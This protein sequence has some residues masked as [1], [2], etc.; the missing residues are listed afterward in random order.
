MADG[1]IFDGLT[2]KTNEDGSTI[3][4]IHVDIYRGKVPKKSTDRVETS[5]SR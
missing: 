4:D 2:A 3:V 1:S 5:K